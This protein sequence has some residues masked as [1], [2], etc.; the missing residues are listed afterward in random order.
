MDRS[1][2]PDRPRTYLEI[3]RPRDRQFLGQ[4]IGLLACRV[5]RLERVAVLSF[6][7]ELSD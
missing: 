5:S 1:R 2:G 6:A 7:Q 4:P 3:R